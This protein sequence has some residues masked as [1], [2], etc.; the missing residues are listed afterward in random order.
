MTDNYLSKVFNTKSEVEKSS[1]T[2]EFIFKLLSALDSKENVG[3]NN[4]LLNLQQMLS[5]PSESAI[6]NNAINSFISICIRYKK[7][8]DEELKEYEDEMKQI[9]YAI[10]NNVYYKSKR[11]KLREFG[12]RIESIE[13]KDDKFLYVAELMDRVIKKIC[14]RLDNE[15]N[16]ELLMTML[17]I[18]DYKEQLLRSTKFEME[19]VIGQFISL[20]WNMYDVIEDSNEITSSTLSNI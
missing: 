5:S 9:E 3:L 11:S 10:K 13:N 16:E 2:L 18:K 20:Y 6:K 7:F 8:F 17:L 1:Y 14:S 12:D 15:D 4:Y 19:F